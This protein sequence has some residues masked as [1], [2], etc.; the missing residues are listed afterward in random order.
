M[1]TYYRTFAAWS[2]FER[3]RETNLQNTGVKSELTY[4]EHPFPADLCLKLTAFPNGFRELALTGRLSIQCIH[5]VHL[6]V[7]LSSKSGCDV[8]THL[9]LLSDELLGKSGL[10]TLERLLASTLSA[11]NILVCSERQVASPNPAWSMYIN[12]QIER[13]VSSPALDSCDRDFMD[14]TCLMLKAT[15]EKDTVSWQ[16]ANAQLQ[17]RIVSDDRREE[18]GNAFIPIPRGASSLTSSQSGKTVNQR[19]LS[20]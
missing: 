12:Q 20:L 14:W 4:P 1:L 5:F 13:S 17:R 2:A 10:T 7:L 9:S 8:P 19:L 11:Y 18:L 3:T 15:T 16:W 6:I